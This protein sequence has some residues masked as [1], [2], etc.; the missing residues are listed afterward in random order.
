MNLLKKTFVVAFGLS[1]T[2]ILVA[3]A[4]EVQ[5]LSRASAPFPVHCGPPEA[6]LAEVVKCK[7]VPPSANSNVPDRS[8]CLVKDNDSTK[9]LLPFRKI[10]TGTIVQIMRIGVHRQV[11][12][13]DGS[14]Y[15]DCVEYYDWK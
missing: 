3:H 12:R 7:F 8:Y 11:L 14:W 13:A 4:N 5:P 15:Y 9:F 1:M 2:L 10:C 6:F